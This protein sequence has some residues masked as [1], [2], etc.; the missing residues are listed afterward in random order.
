[1]GND[2]S[3]IQFSFTEAKYRLVMFPSP[4]DKYMCYFK[5]RFG[6]QRGKGSTDQKMTTL[7]VKLSQM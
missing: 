4:T 6:Q 3:V 1:M 2:V 7:E 5:E